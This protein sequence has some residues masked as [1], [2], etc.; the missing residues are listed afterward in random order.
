MFLSIVE[1]LQNIV[2]SNRK[3]IETLDEEITSFE[4]SKEELLQNEKDVL[5]E[6]ENIDNKISGVQAEIFGLRESKISL[7]K[8]AEENGGDIKDRCIPKISEIEANIQ[9]KLEHLDSL[10]TQKVVAKINH[11]TKVDD[12]AQALSNSVDLDKR[13]GEKNSQ[14]INIEKTNGSF[15]NAMDLISEIGNKCWHLG[16]SD[17]VPNV[18]EC[19][20]A[21]SIGNINISRNFVRYMFSSF[22]SLQNRVKEISSRTPGKNGTIGYKA[23]EVVEARDFLLNC[24]RFIQNNDNLKWSDKMERFSRK[25][26][27]GDFGFEVVTVSYR[28][29][30][31]ATKGNNY[32]YISV[33]EDSYVRD[34]YNDILKHITDVLN[35]I[36]PCKT[37]GNETAKLKQFYRNIHCFYGMH[38]LRNTVVT[39]SFDDV[40]KEVNNP[41]VSVVEGTLRFHAMIEDGYVDCY[42][43]IRHRDVDDIISSVEED[44]EEDSEE[45][46]EKEGKWS[47]IVE[48]G[49]V[50]PTV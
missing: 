20:S 19:P 32:N 33:V 27:I 29:S 31:G 38:V 26:K 44:S 22:Q 34:Q 10:I 17:S 24:L 15:I 1:S 21:N 2:T 8:Y 45:E 25:G 9:E 48:K 47:E 12:S 41:T 18:D 3:V 30:V 13:I 46:S 39:D 42:N 36:A 43:D 5:V 16:I 11:K 37:M 35:I 4:N 28:R 40:F 50:P 6:E 23:G 14:K 49:V 7:E